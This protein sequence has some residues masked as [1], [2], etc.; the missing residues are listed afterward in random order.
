[1]TA[2][3]NDDFANAEA[4]SGVGLLVTGLDTTDAT[5][6]VSEP[7][8]TDES[9]MSW[10]S[11]NTS[12]GATVWFTW[13]PPSDGDYTLTTENSDFDTV[14]AVYEATG[15]GFAGLALLA[16]N[17]EGA[18]NEYG[19]DLAYPP[20][21]SRV[22]LPSIA[23][24][25]TYFIQVGGFNGSTGLLSLS[26]SVGLPPPEPPQF[27]YDDPD[28]E[29]ERV[30]P[31]TGPILAADYVGDAFLI[32]VANNTVLW[33]YD[34]D[35]P[36]TVSPLSPPLGPQNGIR[37][38]LAA[39]SG[40]YVGV[41]DGSISSFGGVHGIWTTDSL[42]T[43]WTLA[44]TIPLAAPQELGV[45][46]V[47]HGGKWVLLTLRG[48]IYEATT[49]EGPWTLLDNNLVGMT[50]ALTNVSSGSVHSLTVID[51]IMVATVWAVLSGD[52]YSYTVPGSSMSFVTNESI[53]NFVWS[54]TDGSTWTYESN[55]GGNYWEMLSYSLQPIRKYDQGFFL[56]C[57]NYLYTAPA[58]SGPWTINTPWDTWL[59]EVELRPPFAVANFGEDA[60][61]VIYASEYAGANSAVLTG[62]SLTDLQCH[63]PSY[64][65]GLL[66]PQ[67]T[68]MTDGSE[69]VLLGDSGPVA[70]RSQGEWGIAL[71]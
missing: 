10:G 61:W 46:I 70:Q 3:L 28:R 59:S 39:H 20:G 52:Y 44:A 54:S 24:A 29:W 11:Y 64:E 31:Y 7:E 27:T 25:T 36:W 26:A 21:W 40:T 67:F 13:S 18:I 50:N 14:L 41:S 63:T 47:Y 68:P 4:L 30:G 9:W 55:I 66:F 32:S 15:P 42:E 1:M 51:G 34:A 53:R 22:G 23:A 6:E 71:A 12:I 5:L 57:F 8:V 38:N 2:P 60:G 43:G 37:S 35:G 56:S 17:D 58:L 19:D 33:S 48:Y 45:G 49:P 69:F 62:P 65:E 16:A